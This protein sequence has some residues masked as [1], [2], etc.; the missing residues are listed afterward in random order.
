VEATELIE[1][2]SRI[3]TRLTEL[4]QAQQG[5]GE[6][7]VEA[8]QHLVERYYGAAYRYLT[9]MLHD[10]NA[11]EDLAQEFAVRFLNGDFEHFDP[12]H[13]RF[14]DYLKAALR[15]LVADYWRKKKQQKEKEFLTA[16]GLEPI[17]APEVEFERVF[18]ES[19]KEELL[20]RTWEALQ[21]D[22]EETGRP[23]YTVLRCATD[24]RDL[25]SAQLATQVGAQLGKPLTPENLRQLLHRARDRF[26][27]LLVDEIARSL[28]T[29]AP[30]A[31]TEELVELEL[32]SYCR[33]AVSGKEWSS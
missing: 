32:M 21:K 14:R 10:A 19:W 24:R 16:E 18:T 7:A 2:L 27:E 8:R 30:E 20:A 11:A 29:T 23:Y 6:A 4:L 1:R 33:G 31:L 25:S 9:G 26:W 17:A 22:Q 28:E 3:K 15:H 12:K 5:Q 13:G